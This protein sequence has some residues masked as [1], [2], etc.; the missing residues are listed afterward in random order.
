VTALEQETVEP[1]KPKPEPKVRATSKASSSLASALVAAQG[2]MPTVKKDE[3]NP[4]FN[5]KFMSLH[6]LIE[7]TRKVLNKHGLALTQFPCTSDLGAPVLRTVLIHGPSGERLEFETPLLM[8][9]QNMQQLGSAITYARRYAWAS[10]LGIAAEDDDDGNSAGTA[11]AKQQKK[12][13]GPPK[14]TDG[15]RR[16]LFAIAAE[17]K[18]PEEQ[19]RQ[20]IADITG[21]PEGSTASIT[22]DRYDDI[23]ALIQLE[24]VP[25]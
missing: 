21:D 2:E 14:I 18:I 9:N 4:H 24:A 7:A 23:V 3:V 1:D 22:V 17:H 10:L 20:F 19:L 12:K 11:P 8:G 15:Q 5:S 16:R 25:F 6:G 13:D